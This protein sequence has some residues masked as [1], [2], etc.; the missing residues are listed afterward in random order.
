VHIITFLK[1]IS[2][3]TGSHFLSVII[4]SISAALKTLTKCEWHSPPR[5]A[6]DISSL[7]TH[8]WIL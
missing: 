8:P 7:I 5:G 2:S 4:L 1:A 6:M 3:L